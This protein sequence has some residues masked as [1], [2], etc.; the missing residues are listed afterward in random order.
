LLKTVEY[1][2]KIPD[3]VSEYWDIK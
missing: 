1:S 2:N 3:T